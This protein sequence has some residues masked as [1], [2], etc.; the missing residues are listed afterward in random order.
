V[1]GRRDL[2]AGP[3]LGPP[4]TV[5]PAVA[6]HLGIKPSVA[7]VP[8]EALGPVV[9]ILPDRPIAERIAADKGTAA[10]VK[11]IAALG[12]DLEALQVTYRAL[13]GDVQEIRDRLQAIAATAKG[14]TPEATALLV[15]LRELDPKVKDAR[16]AYHKERGK[17][18]GDAEA[19]LTVPDP[20][21]FTFD[22]SA[23]GDDRNPLGP[24]DALRSAAADEAATWYSKVMGRAGGA[25]ELAV[26]I[27]Q[28]PAAMEQRAYQWK[29]NVHMDNES[30]TA[31]AIHEVGHA[32]DHLHETG[33]RKAWERSIEFLNYRVGDEVPQKL[34]DV[35]PESKFDDNEFGRKDRFD[36]AFEPK[37][38]Y[39]IGK[40]YGGGVNE[41]LAMGVQ[42]LF[43][44]P[45]GFAAKD[46]EYCAFV[47]GI[48]RGTLR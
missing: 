43:E 21:G 12:N 31:I 33:G 30:G 25:A 36:E 24:L 1:V 37:A 46:P 13:T 7:E 20:I 11:R 32:I 40:K 9:P 6:K 42:K 8:A 44:D 29:G 17:V 38:A 27:G 48:L 41:I 15:R 47:V 34:K 16:S 5:D 28:I 19:I 14:P 4:A 22:R 18:R 45:A 39:Y 3:R 26:G 23:K 10:I 35:F 2:D